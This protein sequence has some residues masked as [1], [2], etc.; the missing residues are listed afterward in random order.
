MV[1][2]LDLMDLLHEKAGLGKSAS[3]EADEF[4]EDVDKVQEIDADENAEAEENVDDVD[5]LDGVPDPLDKFDELWEHL[6]NTEKPIVMYG[7]GDGAEKIYRVLT[8][9]GV[10]PAQFMASDEFVR[11]QNFLGYTVHTLAQ[12]EEM[13]DDFII[14]VCFG[15]ML[16]DVME[17]IYQLSQKYELYAPDVP[18]FGGGLFTKNYVK[19]HVSEIKEVREMFEDE[20]SR[21]VFD[22]IA[23]YRLTGKIN[24]LTDCETPKAEGLSLLKLGEN[25]TYI[26]LGA[27]NGDTVQEFL[28][29]CNYKF[30][31]IYAVEPDARNFAKM[32]RNIYNLSGEKFKCYNAVAWSEETEVDFFHKSGR[33]SAVSGKGRMIKMPAKTVDGILGG[34]PA[35]LIKYD[36]EGC[37]KE[38]LLGST[39]TIGKY[40]PKLIVSLYHRTEDFLTLPILIKKLN[41]N[42]KIFLRHHPYYPA[43]DTNLYCI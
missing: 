35:T 40:Q 5:E 12:I 17:R 16:P 34:K 22:K 1:K 10:K 7:M 26:D 11:G 14:L 30:N 43:W 13:Y 9:N 20:V 38:A 42:Y 24:Y 8:E 28:T 33:N 2:N 32:R 15:S 19:D 29:L 27:Y 25:E 36:V 6:K 23:E 39:N 37:E 31:C 21:F 3:A 41:P 18:V 4:T